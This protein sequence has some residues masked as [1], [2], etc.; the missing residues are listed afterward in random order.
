M[1]NEVIKT[2]NNRISLRKYADKPVT[3]EE[4]DIILHS[5]MRAPTAGNMMLYSIL[6]ITD[7]EIKD[8]LA[9]SCDNQPFIAKAPVVLIFVADYQRWYDY[10][11]ASGISDLTPPCESDLMLATLD[12]MCAAENAVI[13]GESLGVGS[14]YIGDIMEHY[15]MHQE[16]LHLPPWT[17]PVGMLC[18]GHYPEK[19]PRTPRDRFGKEYIVFENQYRQLRDEE[20]KAMFAEKEDAY[21]RHP[22]EKSYAEAFYDRKVNSEFSHEMRRS[23]RVALKN[24]EQVD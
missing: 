20:L 16:L 1:P 11:K 15:E 14:C 17:F 8:K 9:V 10:F 2:I 12:A 18:F 21:N 24:W 19:M 13:A 7:Q 23:F 6:N 4:L 22:R 5:A 3:K